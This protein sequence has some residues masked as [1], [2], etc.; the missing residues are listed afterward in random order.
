MYCANTHP[1]DTTRML[2]L[3]C[4]TITRIN[5]ELK[6]GAPVTAT[7]VVPECSDPSMPR[8]SVDAVTTATTAQHLHNLPRPLPQTADPEKT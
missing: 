5:D 2:P 6:A 3:L 7:V 1:R 4:K 8:S